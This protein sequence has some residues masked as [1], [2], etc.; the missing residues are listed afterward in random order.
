MIRTFKNIVLLLSTLFFS[1]NLNAKIFDEVRAG[2]LYHDVR[3]THSYEDGQDIN[4]E[5][6]FAQFNNE[7]M[8]IIFDPRV[9]LGASVNTK[10]YTSQYY[11]GLTWHFYFDD[12]VFMVLSFGGEIHSGNI[13]CQNRK[14]RAYGSRFLFRESASIGYDINQNHNISIMIDHS[15]NTGMGKYN[16]GLTN[17]G[18]RYGH[19][20]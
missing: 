14:K 13:N 15:S 1:L 8:N 20:F 2:I 11:S 19:K 18:L 10:G 9:H 12:A 5:M 17:L 4:A 16:P 6:L 3:S 7:I